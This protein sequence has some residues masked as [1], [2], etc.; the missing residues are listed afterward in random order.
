MASPG[1]VAQWKDYRRLWVYLR[2]YK[3]RLALVLGISLAATSLS[4]VQPF[5][6]KLLID[7]ALL[8]HDMHA[9]VVVSVLMFG[10]T[11][12]GFVLNILSSYRYV[13]VSADMLFDMRLALFR[14]LQKLSPRF[15]AQF[16][17]GDLLSRLNN[18][19][20]EVQRVSADT[21]LSVLSNV[22]FLVGSIVVMLWLNWRLFFISVILIPA[23][24]YT[25]FRF[26]KKLTALTALLRARSADLGSLFVDTILGMRVVISLRA[27]EHEA[28][29]F[30][31]RNGAFVR[32]MLDVQIASFMTGALPGTILTA[33]TSV[34]FLYGGWL[35]FHGAM[36]IGT[37]VA[38]MAY[39]TRLMSPV[40]NLMGLTS[41]MAS[42]RVSLGR[43]FEL[44]DTTPDV[45][46]HPGALPLPPLRN[47]IRIEN[48]SLRYDRAP[49]LDDISVDIPAGS[50]YAILGPSGVGK[51]TFAD[52]LV[53]YLDPDQGRILIDGRDI[54]YAPLDNLREQIMLVDQSPYLFNVS[55]AENIAY[56][57]PKAT[58]QAIEEA[59]SAAGLDELIARL[60]EGYQTKTGERGLALSAGERQRIALARAFLRRPNVL[61]LDEPTSALD[62]DTEKLIASNLRLAL[63]G[64]TLIVITHRPALAQVADAVI[65]IQGGKAFLTHDLSI[66][67]GV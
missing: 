52:L 23:C 49:V 3:A 43:I 44:F 13:T 41:G 30:R 40:Q 31:E 28:N 21:L 63:P 1:S 20:G 6:S 60:P 8:K 10:V 29:R 24:V 33:A 19:I 4:L 51:S 42:A 38:F 7:G 15:Y 18:D 62:G 22:V 57:F 27:G 32:T 66:A 17:L 65:T 5:L 50:F 47:S 26:Q 45:T 56:A 53:R 64:C 59:G 12:A 9:L 36:S 37:L 67:V 11:V 16:R 61:I 48:V 25:F 55:I 14:H 58:P 39:Y 35:I 2:P 46:D 54:R 34:V